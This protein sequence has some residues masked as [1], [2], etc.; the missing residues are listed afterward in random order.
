MRFDMFLRKD[1]AGK[2]SD[3]V[4]QI[5]DW[6]VQERPSSKSIDA[7]T[8]SVVV[9][10]HCI[11]PDRPFRMAGA[12]GSGDFPCV[13]YGDSVVYLV[14]AQAR[15]YEAELTKLVEKEVEGANLLELMWLPADLE[16]AKQSFDDMLSRLVG[17]T[18][19]S[20]CQKSD[21]YKLKCEN[22][23]RLPSPVDLIDKLVHPEPHDAENIRVQLLST[24]EPGSLIRLMKNNQLSSYGMPTY[25]LQDTT[26]SIPLVTASTALFFEIAKRYA[27]TLAMEKGFIYISLSKSH[28]LPYMDLIEQMIAEKFKTNEHWFFRISSGNEYSDLIGKRQIPP[29]GAVT[30]IFRLHKTTQP[31]RLDVDLNWWNSNVLDPDPDIIR[32]REIQ[33]FRD[34]DFASHD[35]RCYGYP[36]PIKACHDVASLTND[37]RVALRK[38]VIDTAVAKGLKR[39]N[40]VDPSIPTGHK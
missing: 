8:N 20:V 2:I 33:M 3:T 29:I 34:I 11:T 7:L 40:F 27:C 21:Y 14:T 30:Y 19:E 6:N 15:M 26:L 36:Y 1:F 4:D 35:Q 24:A 38:Y 22:G 23:K 28:N 10:D 9:F 17:E 16:K 37:E 18:L 39:K 25:I 5:C 12:D 31:M 13:T 32:K